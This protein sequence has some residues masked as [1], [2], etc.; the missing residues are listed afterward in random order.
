MNHLK[1]VK[2]AFKSGRKVT[3][4]RYK[5]VIF[6]EYTPVQGWTGQFHKDCLEVIFSNV[7]SE[8]FKNT[9][10]RPYGQQ[11]KGTH[12]VGVNGTGQPEPGWRLEGREFGV[13]SILTDHKRRVLHFFKR[14]L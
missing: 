1:V 14:Y 13:K 5:E 7:F 9:S 12:H 2:P 8:Q 4:G 11:G 3:K 10:S 6:Y